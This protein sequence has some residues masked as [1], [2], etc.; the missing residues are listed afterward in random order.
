MTAPNVARV[1]SDGAVLSVFF[2]DVAAGWEQWVMLSADRHHD[3]R[4][5]ARRV[6]R[7]HLELA[8]ERGALIIDAGDLFCAM[9]GK[10]DP[11]SSMDDIR[12]EDVGEDY[13]D[14]IVKHAAEDYGPFAAN[15]LLIGR[16]NHDTNI[17]K[18]HGTDLVSNLAHRLNA[19][20]GATV[21]VG[22]YG[23]WVRFMMTMNKTKRQ[24]VRLKYFHGHGGG[25]PVTRGVIQTNRQA[26]F[27]PDAD[28][29]LN[30]HVHEAYTVMVPR[31]RLSAAGKQYRDI[32]KH[33]RTPGY[34]DTY[35]DGTAGWDVERGSGPKPIG[36]IWL[37]L[38]YDATSSRVETEITEAV[39]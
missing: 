35:G 3:N 1:T 12:P 27:Q 23:G 7:R 15:W 37:R 10:Y 30:G 18:R 16:G 39:Q 5:C 4:H 36:C 24:S 17:R 9:Q 20:Y 13:L 14:R 38:F 8:A 21:H 2:D 26:V 11:R 34:N 28:I 6:E 25:G 19:D 32:Q 33:V 29:V 22:G 31:E